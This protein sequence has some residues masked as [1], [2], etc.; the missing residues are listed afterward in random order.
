[1]LKKRLC[2]EVESVCLRSKLFRLKKQKLFI[3][4]QKLFIIRKVMRIKQ[5]L[6]MEPLIVVKLHKHT[7][8]LLYLNILLE[9]IKSIRNYT[10][11]I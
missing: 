5:M 6:L 1:M 11:R 2:K 9:F 7:S 10:F 4:R 8:N 3:R